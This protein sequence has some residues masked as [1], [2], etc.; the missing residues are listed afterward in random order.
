MTTTLT[1]EPLDDTVGAAVVGVDGDRLLADDALA[2]WCLDALEAHG[3]LVFAGLHIDDATQVA[4]AKS[5]GRV[6]LFPHNDPPEIFRVT[7]DPAKNPAAAYLRGTF[8]WHIDG[9]TDDVPIMATV[10]SAHAV[11]ATGG[12]TEFASSYQAYE[13]LS[14]DDKERAESTRVV[15][16]FEAAQRLVKDD[17]SPEELALWRRRPSKEHPLVWRH[18]SGRRSLVLGATASHVVGMDHDQ[19]RAYLADLLARSTAPDQ[20]Y[21]HHWE[22][23]DLVIWDNRGVLHRAL[24]Y[25]PASPRDM[26]RCTL[27]GDEVIT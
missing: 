16:S 20:V 24:P 9:C 4:L 6:E 17:P 26:H 3:V 12:E 27:S 21:R 7:L 8:D 11:A 19:G 22:V 1:A 2:G 25:D 10:L 15:H 13:H 18:R 5:L 14:A 23:G